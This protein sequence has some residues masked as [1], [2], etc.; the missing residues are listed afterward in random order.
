VIYVPWFLQSVIYV[1]RFPDSSV[2]IATGLRAERSG[3]DIRQG[4]GIFRY[5]AQTGSGAH[6]AS[7]PMDTGI[8]YPGVKR[9]EREADHSPPSSAEVKKAWNCTRVYPKVSG[10]AAWSENCK[11]YSSL[12]LDA[13]V[14][15][16][17]E[18]V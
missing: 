12:S 3:F 11:W 6:P 13:V 5:R 15:L 17:C 16:L 1:L 9:L 4:L 2:G 18:S 8:T 10:L 14:S 7:Y